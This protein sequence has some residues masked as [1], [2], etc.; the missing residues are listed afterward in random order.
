MDITLSYTRLQTIPF[1]SY[2][3]KA[4]DIFNL[5]LGSSKGVLEKGSLC[6]RIH[7]QNEY[8]PAAENPSQER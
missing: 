8:T 3:T 5:A 1:E 6:R 7:N 4:V 2:E